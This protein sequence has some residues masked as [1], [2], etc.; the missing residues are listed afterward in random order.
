MVV[1]LLAHLVAQC[2]DLIIFCVTSLFP[3]YKVRIAGILLAAPAELDSW[4]A[5]VQESCSEQ[6]AGLPQ[7][8]A[9]VSALF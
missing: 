6:V 7:R 8:C 4:A 9:K 1:P 3:Q 2:S 5:A